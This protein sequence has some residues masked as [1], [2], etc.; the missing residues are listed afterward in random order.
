MIAGA[1][2][3]RRLS[4]AAFMLFGML[5]IVVRSE[6]SAST[7]LVTADGVSEAS[8]TA[9]DARFV[10]VGPLR[11]A[12]TRN[13][14]GFTRLNARTIRVAVQGAGVPA[15]ATAVIL[16]VTVAS[17]RDAGYVTVWPD[18]GPRPTT[19]NLNSTGAGQTLAATVST[20]L[21]SGAVAIY[22]T[23]AAEVIVDV[24]G[25]FVPAAD[26]ATSG[27][28][29]SVV[30]TRLLDSRSS[31]KPRSGATVN[32]PLPRDVPADA[33]ALAVNLTVDQTTDAG[34]FTMWP[35]GA[36]VPLASTGNSD[37]PGQTRAIFGVI[38]VGSAGL[39]VFTQSGAHL[40][41][42]VVGYF[43]GP[44]A[45]QSTEGLFRS[46][47]P[48]RLIDT[49]QSERV[50]PAQ[51]REIALPDGAGA[52]WVNV[53]TVGALSP[54]FVTLFAAGTTRPTASTVNATTA[55][56]VVANAAIVSA[57]GRGVGVFSASGEHIVIDVAGYF[58]LDPVSA[59]LPVVANRMPTRSA[60]SDVIGM[61]F[62]GRPI[63]VV[64]MRGSDTP[65]RSVLVIGE[66]HGE[67]PAGLRVSAALVARAA[68]MPTDLELWV[69]PTMNPDGAATGSRGNGR[70]VDLNRNFDGGANPWCPTPG[71]GS[72]VGPQNAGEGPLSEPESQAMWA[73]VSRV[74]PD[75]IVAYHQPLDEVDCS[76]FRGPRLLALCSDYA[77]AAQLAV[78]RVGYIDASG[79]LTNSYMQANPGRWAFTI[80]F[81]SQPPSSS[82]IDQAA[83][84]IYSTLR[85]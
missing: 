56:D 6:A 85:R 32:V 3:L 52:V 35:A 44:S 9:V 27:R 62:N 34:Y 64:R 38:P 70:G 42:D 2:R 12:D 67:E 41:V 18:G 20:P 83:A 71:C 82:E 40:I 49:R 15:D 23:M 77:A 17:T 48:K 76:P 61:S 29:V 24:T 22:A 14:T 66:M 10:P 79:T 51:Q 4:A 37:G 33:T 47:T 72:G 43:T 8:A 53:T 60:F 59:T 75:V 16:T 25:V 73:F 11:L 39:N 63:A 57:S 36:P 5:G 65:T 45:L 30:P 7:G 84:A 21:H 54:S 80:E 55:D 74:K 31:R 13:G 78:N 68:A 46:V 58:A 1:R 50:W 69:V 28:F 81:G 19:S 26:G